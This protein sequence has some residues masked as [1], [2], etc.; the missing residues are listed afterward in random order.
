MVGVAGV[1]GLAGVGEAGTCLKLVRRG[2]LSILG[3]NMRGNERRFSSEVEV[4]DDERGQSRADM[5]TVRMLGDGK[6]AFEA[7][8]GVDEW[9]GVSDANSRVATQTPEMII[10]CR[11]A[12]SV[13]M[14]SFA[15]RLSIKES[16]SV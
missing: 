3:L 11:S 6:V 4:S 12:S 16:T 9:L 7:R 5:E 15:V 10:K 1:V 8:T 13:S 2:S 14:G